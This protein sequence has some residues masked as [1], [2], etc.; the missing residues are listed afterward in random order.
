MLG[1][2]AP[3]ASNLPFPLCASAIY[4]FLSASHSMEQPAGTEARRELR[5][6]GVVVVLAQ[7]LPLPQRAVE[8]QN[9]GHTR[10]HPLLT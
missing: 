2:V 6:P 8:P 7:R 10:T 5:D 1:H 3:D 9:V 4:H